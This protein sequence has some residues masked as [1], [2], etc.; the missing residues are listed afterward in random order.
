MNDSTEAVQGRIVV[1]FSERET[2]EQIVDKVVQA[3][4]SILASGDSI[5]LDLPHEPTPVID[6]INSEILELVTRDPGLTDQQ[7]AQRLGRSRQTVN[8]RRRKLQAMG[9]RVR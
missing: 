6:P 9:Y 3:V 1:E 8:T 4:R 5:T 2:F 7:V